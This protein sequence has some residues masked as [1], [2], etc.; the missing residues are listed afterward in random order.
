MCV[1]LEAPCV[2]DQHFN[3]QTCRCECPSGTE[4]LEN[5]LTC[6]PQAQACVLSTAAGLRSVAAAGTP[7]LEGTSA[8]DRATG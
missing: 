5:G 2:G 7:A 6:C 1:S 4:L 8:P 3:P